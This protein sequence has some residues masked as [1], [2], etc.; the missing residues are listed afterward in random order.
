M[1]EA[2]IGEI[3][4]AAFNFPPKGWA[5]CNGQTLPI[6]QNQALFSLLGTAYGGN[7]QTTFA[8][9]NLQGRVPVHVGQGITRGGIG[10]EAQHAL[11]VAEMPAHQLTLSVNNSTA[12]TGN[13]NVPAQGN[14]LGASINH[15]SSGPDAPLN[16]YNSTLTNQ[17][18][19]AG[20][21]VGNNGGNQPHENRQPFQVVSACIALVG[22]YPSRN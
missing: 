4:F 1:S 13:T 2:F 16:I 6:N 7:G 10:G 21:M 12:A 18:P 22:I 11:T 3:R 20:G 19:V 9:P 8:L 17:N 15:P 5:L 14:V